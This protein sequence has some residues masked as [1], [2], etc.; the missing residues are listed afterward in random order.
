MLHL[1]LKNYIKQNDMHW[2]F[3]T[4]NYYMNY[5]TKLTH[6]LSH[7]VMPIINF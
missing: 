2:G 6:P 1:N 5:I 4:I 3:A 7:R